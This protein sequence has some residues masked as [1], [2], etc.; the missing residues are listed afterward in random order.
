M[1]NNNINLFYE[2]VCLE[3]ELKGLKEK[4][5]NLK[6]KNEDD[7]EMF[8][9]NE[10]IPIARKRGFNFT[11][12]E[13]LSYENKLRQELSESDLENVSGGVSLKKALSFGLMSLSL[14]NTF[15]SSAI[16]THAAVTKDLIKNTQDDVLTEMS[17]ANGVDW[18]YIN[19]LN[20]IKG[21]K[22]LDSGLIDKLRFNNGYINSMTIK[23]SARVWNKDDGPGFAYVMTYLFPSSGGD[24]SS[25]SNSIDFFSSCNPSPKLMANLFE[26]IHEIRENKLTNSLKGKFIDEAVK[27][28]EGKSTKK[29]KRKK[30]NAFLNNLEIMIKD[31]EQKVLPKYTTEKVLLAYF[32]DHFSNEDDV[33]N[34]YKS[35]LQ[36]ISESK[37][38]DETKE[39]AIVG[40]RNMYDNI[41]LIQNAKTCF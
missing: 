23:G 22:A 13:L 41:N 10:I 15:L 24:L 19:H 36:T 29:Q 14:A 18:S 12:L 32:V 1:I 26:V 33:K 16:H 39:S 37:S 2:S 8:I 31:Q 5:I 4:I 30:L 17:T 35:I 7:L 40:F 11:V 3:D 25:T 6:F 27:N 38:N 20:L 34:F 28:E 9:S 21:R